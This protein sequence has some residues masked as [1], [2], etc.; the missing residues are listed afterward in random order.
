MVSAERVIAYSEDI[1]SEAP[2]ETDPLIEKPS[3]TWPESGKI[4]LK[5][6]LYRHSETTP[7]VL[8]G[9]TA[10]IESGEK[11]NCGLIVCELEYNHRLAIL[12]ILIHH[13]HVHVLA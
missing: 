2:F 9:L 1:P 12:R 5:D 8:K 11:V 3:S 7:L 4:E 13:F 10:V 6:V